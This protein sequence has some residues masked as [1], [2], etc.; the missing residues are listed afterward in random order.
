MR[1]GKVL[2]LSATLSIGVVFVATL[3]VL[4]SLYR[5]SIERGFDRRL[6]VHLNML[7]ATLSPAGEGN[8]PPR[9]IGDPLFELPVSGWYW[10]VTPLD[11]SDAAVATSKSLWE[12]RLPHLD[13]GEA[14]TS[15]AG[16]RHGYVRG[17]EQQRLRLLERTVDVGAQD[18]YLVAVAGDAAEIDDQVSVFRLTGTA[19]LGLSLILVSLALFWQVRLIGTEPEPSLEPA[20]Q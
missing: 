12:R 5:R 16:F 20:R 6:G 17:P 10:Q 7:L 19:A 14:Q 8:Q 3:M 13:A 4:S 2:A 15:G 18:R 9:F 1:S 11:R